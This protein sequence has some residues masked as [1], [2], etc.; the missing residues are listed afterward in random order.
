MLQMKEQD[1]TP[2]KQRNEMEIG[3]LHEKEFRVM[4]V[5]II[6]NL[7]KRKEAQTKKILEMLNR[8]ER[9]KEQTNRGEQYSNWNK[10]ILEVI[11]S[12][13]NEAED[14]GNKLEDRLLEITAAEQNKEKIM[15]RN[16]DSLRELWDKIKHSNIC[17]IGF[18]E[19]EREKK[20]RLDKIFEEIIAKNFTYV[21]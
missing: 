20:G 8:A 3:S 9:L 11:T 15:K 6:Q 1:K 16:E 10:I 17:I 2:R 12:R 13:I 7:R 5:K 14:Q 4:I 18:P 21:G 19:E